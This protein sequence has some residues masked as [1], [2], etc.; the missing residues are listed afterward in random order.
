MCSV[1]A[2][3]QGS[4][5][6]CTINPRWNDDCIERSIGLHRNPAQPHAAGVLFLF[7]HRLWRYDLYR[8]RSRVRGSAGKF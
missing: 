6:I 5:R 1:Q 7:G 2:G 4:K 8:P 3:E